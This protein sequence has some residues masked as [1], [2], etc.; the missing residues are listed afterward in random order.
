MVLPSLNILPHLEILIIDQIFVYNRQSTQT[1]TGRLAELL[2]TKI[3]NLHLTYVHMNINADL[4]H[5]AATAPS[6]FPNLRNVKVGF[7]D[8][9]PARAAE[10]EEL[11][12]VEAAFAESGVRLTWGE[13]F[14]GPYVYTTIPGGTPGMTIAHVNKAVPGGEPGTTVVHVP[15]VTD[16]DHN[17]CH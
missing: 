4:L 17:N 14:T 8:V 9:T 1:N 5:L 16:S 3:R 15:A 10:M 12:M 2:P 11:P 6:N 7:I 13:D